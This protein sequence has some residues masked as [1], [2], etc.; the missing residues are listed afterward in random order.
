MESLTINV[1][2]RADGDY[3]YQVWPCDLDEAS[4]RND[5]GSDEGADNGGVCTGSLSDAVGMAADAARELI[6]QSK[7]H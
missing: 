4:E 1:F 6:K 3:D 7:P 2:L 5:N